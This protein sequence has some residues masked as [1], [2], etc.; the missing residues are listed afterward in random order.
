MKALLLR[1][2]EGP[3]ILHFFEQQLDPVARHMAAFTAAD[4]TEWDAY[5]A[6]WDRI[7]ANEEVTAQTIVFEGQ[8]AGN[9]LSFE[10]LGRREVGYWLG[11]E[12]WGRGIATAALE[13][14]L[15]LVDERPLYAGVVKDNVAS[16][17]VL[18][19]CGFV[20]DGEKK[21]FANARGAE[22]EEYVM[23]LGLAARE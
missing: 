11:R 21:G 3:D 23:K 12:F 18:E 22:V 10:Y 9:I 15:Q 14:F 1:D 20:V 16:R 6:R 4:S 17:R 19:K 5:A 8:V 7:L 13:Q 2:V